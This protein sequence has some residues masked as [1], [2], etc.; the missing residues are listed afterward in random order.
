[1][2]CHPIN[3]ATGSFWRERGKECAANFALLPTAGL[4]GRTALGMPLEGFL[5]LTLADMHSPEFIQGNGPKLQV[6]QPAYC[7]ILSILR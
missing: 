3:T 1:M 2:N 6:R 7:P 5:W 4:S